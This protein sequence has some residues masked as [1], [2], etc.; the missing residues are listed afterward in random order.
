MHPSSAV[1]GIDLTDAAS[2]MATWTSTHFAPTARVTLV[3][4]IHL[5]RSGVPR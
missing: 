5:P 1:V 3:H 4:V 2:R